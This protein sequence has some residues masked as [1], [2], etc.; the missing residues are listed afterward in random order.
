MFIKSNPLLGITYLLVLF[1]ASFTGNAQN[2]KDT[3]TG[4]EIPVIGT[5]ST[6]NATV[7]TAA[8]DVNPQ[9]YI[10]LKVKDN[11]E[12]YTRYKF[13]LA[14]QITPVLANGAL[15]S[16][17]KDITLSVENNYEEVSSN[18]IDIAHYIS[19]NSYGVNIVV[20]GNTFE[21]SQ[22]NVSNNTSIP[23]NI[24]LEIAFHTERYQE[25]TQEAPIIQNHGKVNGNRDLRIQWRCKIL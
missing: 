20:L 4:A 6:Q 25:L 23:N 16:T 8:T 14:L 22:G 7:N 11:T 5:L 9:T 18:V 24:E 21:N 10:A 3:F 15:A 19:N 13:S 12:P 2:F 1:I 17:S